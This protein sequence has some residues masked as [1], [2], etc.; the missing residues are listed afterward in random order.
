MAKKLRDSVVVITGASSGIGRVTALE[1][2][3]RGAR[4]ALAARR[5]EALDEVAQICERLGGRAIAVPTDVTDEAAVQELARRA[6]Q[7]YGKIDVWVNNAAVTL[8]GRFEDTP[9]EAYRRVI[10]TNLLGTVN[11]ARAALPYFREN[12][13]GTLINIASML[14]AAPYPYLNPYVTA[15]FAVRGFSA[16]LREELAGANISV[17]TILPATM[18]TPLYQQ[19]AN[20]MGR[21]PKAS[22]PVY[23]PEEV[24]EA[25]VS[26][27]EKPR[28][29][30]YVGGTARI[31]SLLNTVASGMYE[32][33]AS[34]AGLRSQFS[35]DSSG[36][37]EGN[38]YEPLPQFATA[39]G[40]W[41]ETQ[42]SGGLVRWSA[43]TALTAT[44]VMG[45][46]WALYRMRQDHG[47][48][49]FSRF[50]DGGRAAKERREET[51]QVPGASARQAEANISP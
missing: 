32:R 1:F 40:G 18:D 20:Y 14:S 26:C 9:S 31:A 33:S 6:Y 10:D 22:P 24:A 29:E 2:A 44:F 25:I 11:G 7:E 42:V 12:G 23:D 48:C 37:S 34:K 38:L 21:T 19:G 16:A 30:V 27:A 41:Q 39:R 5:E 47:Q 35:N 15:K 43:R 4:L 50:G 49:L 51:H 28:R 13:S 46:I 3:K 8:F 17:C 36:P 45:G